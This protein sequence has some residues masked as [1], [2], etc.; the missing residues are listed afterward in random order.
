MSASQ[1]SCI[2]G[3][4]SEKQFPLLS[5]LQRAPTS[6]SKHA[7]ASLFQF[8]KYNN[9]TS[10]KLLQDTIRGK[11]QTCVKICFSSKS[12][13]KTHASDSPLFPVSL[14]CFAQLYPSFSELQSGG[15][16]AERLG[17]GFAFR[18]YP[19]KPRSQKVCLIA[20]YLPLKWC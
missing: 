10:K 11:T 13:R 8:R 15:G 18:H 14:M 19:L 3:C 6:P 20:D 9:L 16:T 4:S 17:V 12:N 1:N 7:S 5:S 2:G